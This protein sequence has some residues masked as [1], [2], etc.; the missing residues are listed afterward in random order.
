MKPPTGRLHVYLFAASLA[1]IL[2][3]AAVVISIVLLHV[4]VRAFESQ[5]FRAA[6]LAAVG[7]A[8]LVVRWLVRRARRKAE[9]LSRS[10]ANLRA[11]RTACASKRAAREPLRARYRHSAGTTALARS[12]EQ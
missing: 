12:S 9:F 10:Q 11:S 7:C 1:V 3:Q 2:I 4:P 8:V 6:V 5:P